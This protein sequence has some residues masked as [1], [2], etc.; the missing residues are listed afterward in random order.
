M[1]SPGALKVRR[2]RRKPQKLIRPLR[3]HPTCLHL[4]EIPRQIKNKKVR[5]PKRSSTVL[6]SDVT[7]NSNGRLVQLG[8]NAD[9]YPGP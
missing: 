9:P 8:A 5:L 7:K 4:L 2:E 6:N 1:G 3:S